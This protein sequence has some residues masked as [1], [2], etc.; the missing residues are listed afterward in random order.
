[1]RAITVRAPGGPEVLELVER[2]IPLPGKHEVRVR[3][4]AS[5]VNRADLL[6]RIGAYPAPPGSPADV[7]GLE[8]AGVIDALGEDAEG[9]VGDPVMGIVGGGGYAEAVVVHGRQVVR[10]PRGMSVRDAGAVPEV[11]MTAYDALHRQMAL[12]MGETVLIHAVGSGVGSAAAQLARAAG[13]RVIGTSR[14]PAKLDRALALGMDHGVLLG[15]GDWAQRVLDLTDGRGADV[16]LDLVGGPYLAGT[17]SAL[18]VGGRCIVVGTTAG[19]SGPVDLRVLM[20]RRLSMTGT[21]L[22]ARPLEEKIA[23]AR[24]FEAKVIPLLERGTLRPVIDRFHP[25]EEVGE[26]HRRLASNDTF[27]KLVILWE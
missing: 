1:M 27:G 20:G 10:V 24:D 26:A 3:V 11:F 19:G 25:P 12:A 13:A 8:F 6:Q 21:V 14:T 7:P 2:P 5:G 18:A 15:D 23:L 16:A 4:V 9:R 22:R 17:L